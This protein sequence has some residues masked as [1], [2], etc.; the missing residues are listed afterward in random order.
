M[1]TDTL[2]KTSEVTIFVTNNS[3]DPQSFLIF[4]DFPSQSVNGAEPWQN[5]WAAAPAVGNGE[6]A[7]FN[8]TQE[9]YA[10]CGV[11]P[12]ALANG[13]VI[14]TQDTQS[15]ALYTTEPGTV[16]PMIA[17]G[18]SGVGFNKKNLTTQ[19]IVPG[20]FEIAAQEWNESSIRQ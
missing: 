10:I 7:E 12:E 5:V 16:V 4:N 18:E 14:S 15:V 13:V 2:I 19:Q 11:S 1:T 20:S 9:F 8:I 3:T 17:I 6:T